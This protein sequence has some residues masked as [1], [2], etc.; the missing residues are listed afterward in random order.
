MSNLKRREP[1]GSMCT[2]PWTR[3]KWRDT[4]LMKTSPRDCRHC[5]RLNKGKC[6]SFSTSV[7]LISHSITGIYTGPLITVLTESSG[8]LSL[9]VILLETF[10]HDSEG[11]AP[12]DSSCVSGRSGQ[13]HMLLPSLR[14][15]VL[16]A[17]TLLFCESSDK[18]AR[19]TTRTVLQQF[20]SLKGNRSNAI[21]PGAA[22]L[23]GSG[24]IGKARG[25][26]RHTLDYLLILHL[27]H[28]P[29]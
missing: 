14:S 29:W 7:K 16:S 26:L 13:Q 18:L 12:S 24:N 17:L 8:V 10:D 9:P 4:S 2:F 28:Y 1:E 15:V 21:I 19:G 3:L 23:P 25:Q 5:A 6:L 27:L 20:Y 22:W 11:V